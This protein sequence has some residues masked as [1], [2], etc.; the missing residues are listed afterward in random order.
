MRNS[1]SLDWTRHSGDLI[2]APFKSDFIC[3]A[4]YGLRMAQAYRSTWQATLPGPISCSDNVGH[5]TSKVTHELITATRNGPDNRQQAL[6]EYAVSS[7]IRSQKTITTKLLGVQSSVEPSSTA[8]TAFDQ[9]QI[10]WLTREHTHT[11]TQH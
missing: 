9:D 11:Y 6:P 4:T 2:L 3:T 7:L 10:G 5:L 8:A 1:F